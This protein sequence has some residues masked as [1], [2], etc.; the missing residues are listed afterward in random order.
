MVGETSSKTLSK[1]QQTDS[2]VRQR[3]RQ[4]MRQRRDGAVLGQA[5][6]SAPAAEPRL[7]KRA[8]L[9]VAGPKRKRRFGAAIWLAPFFIKSLGNFLLKILAENLDVLLL[10]HASTDHR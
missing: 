8:K 9:Q 7:V 1:G 4:S 10:E 5:L 3:L 6:T 2:F